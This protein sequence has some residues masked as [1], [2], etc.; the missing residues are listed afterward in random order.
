MIQKWEQV[1]LINV[2]IRDARN[3]SI[4]GAYYQVIPLGIMQ[5]IM[6]DINV[7]CVGDVAQEKLY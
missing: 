2:I 1:E 5:S 6:Q 4:T 3:H 7:R